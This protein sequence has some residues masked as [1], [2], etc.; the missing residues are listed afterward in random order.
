[1]AIILKI[2]YLFLA[3]GT[4]KLWCGLIQGSRTKTKND[5]NQIGV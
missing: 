1:M 2:T 3:N 5:V 4:Y